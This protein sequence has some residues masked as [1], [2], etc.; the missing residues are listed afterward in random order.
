MSAQKGNIRD[1]VEGMR[2]QNRAAVLINADESDHLVKR[3][4]GIKL[5]LR[6]LIRY[7]ERFNRCLSCVDDVA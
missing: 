4:F 5:D 1:I 7:A 3:A 6:M 2:Y